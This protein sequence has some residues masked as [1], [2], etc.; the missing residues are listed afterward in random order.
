MLVRSV[1]FGLAF[2]VLT[3]GCR[4]PFEKEARYRARE[5]E[6]IRASRGSSRHLDDRYEA[7]Q[8]LDAS[9]YGR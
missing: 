4:T 9:I 6:I 8:Q 7:I 3:I 1:L 5:Q 2:L